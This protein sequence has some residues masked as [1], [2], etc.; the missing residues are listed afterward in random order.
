MRTPVSSWRLAAAL[1]VAAIFPFAAQAQSPA[2]P[3][4]YD[5][6]V[7]T[8]PSQIIIANPARRSITFCNPNASISVAVCPVVQRRTAATLTCAFNGRGSVTIPA[9]M[10]FSLQQPPG[11]AVPLSTAWNGVAASGT[12]N[13]TVFEIE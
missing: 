7:T 1:A 2:P 4:V 8:A 10:C 5:A 11:S 3:Y 13:I 9:T 6:Q 12:A